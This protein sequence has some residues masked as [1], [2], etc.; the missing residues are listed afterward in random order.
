M[1]LNKIILSKIKDFG[2]PLIVKDVF[3]DRGTGVSGYVDRSALYKAKGISLEH[4]D[5][6]EKIILKNQ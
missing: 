1:K 4:F 6:G 2:Y 3:L 5:I